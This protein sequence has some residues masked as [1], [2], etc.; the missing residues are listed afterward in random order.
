MVEGERQRRGGEIAETG[1]MFG[2]GRRRL[3]AMGEGSGGGDGGVALVLRITLYFF[4]S[5]V[6][7]KAT[8]TQGA[9]WRKGGPDYVLLQSPVQLVSGFFS[10]YPFGQGIS[11]NR[12]QISR[13][14]PL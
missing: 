6:A 10:G 9:L 11:Q 4:A 1:M 14:P 2:G 3:A 12:W 5:Y 8:R 7:G 13:Y